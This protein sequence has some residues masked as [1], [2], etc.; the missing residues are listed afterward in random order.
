MQAL[1]PRRGGYPQLAP[2]EKVVAEAPLG[3]DLALLTDRRLVVSGRDFENSFAL[4]Q[5]GLV[6]STFRRSAREIA[7]GAALLLA[8][9][10]LLA[11]AGP[12]NAAITAQIASFDAGAADSAGGSL[13]ASILRGA[14]NVVRGLPLAGF[15]LGALGLV[16][17][18]L[19]ALGQ[20]SVSVHAG[21]GELVY[22][23]RG[24]DGALDAFAR[25]V[26]RAL[27]LPPRAATRA[28]APSGTEDVE[29][30]GRRA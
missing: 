14:R 3:A 22:S 8:G 29:K 11:I 28:T 15:A 17:G 13:A 6:R 20:T 7:I 9:L 24:R 30:P 16:R 21:G 19:G 10:A 2:G 12:A 27:P 18:A 4:A 25:E 26:A 1:Q 5:I 23:R